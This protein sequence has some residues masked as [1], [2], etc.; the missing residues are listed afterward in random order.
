MANAL[1]KIEHAL[2]LDDV[3]PS[4]LLDLRQS[5][6]ISQLD[7]NGRHQGADHVD[8]LQ[9]TRDLNKVH[10]ETHIAERKH[11]EEEERANAL[12]GEPDRCSV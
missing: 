9:R 1:H 6:V 4:T 3:S 10:E 11:T 12:I 8:A 7:P 2:H 5:R